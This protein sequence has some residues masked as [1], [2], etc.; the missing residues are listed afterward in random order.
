MVATPR[1][2]RLGVFTGEL[3]GN[4]APGHGGWGHR[5]SRALGARASTTALTPLP[6]GERVRLGAGVGE[7]DLERALK[8]LVG[9][10]D[11]LM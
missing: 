11:E 4:G 10:A 8:Y 2:C 3:S 7:G 6:E 1:F 9:L 5:R